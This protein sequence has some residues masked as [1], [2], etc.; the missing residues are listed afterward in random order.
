MVPPP[1]KALDAF[2]NLRRP[3]GGSPPLSPNVALD[4]ATRKAH[5][6]LGT[7]LGLMF[8]IS[9]L[10]RSNVGF[11]KEALRV[12]AHIGD[13][14]YALGAGIFFI[15]Y[16]G[17]EVPS[18][19]I[20]HRVGARVWLS[21]IMVTWGIAS[22]LMM[23]VRNESSFYL[24]RFLVGLAEA[25][26]SPGVVLYS[27]Y[28]FPERERGKALGTYYMG[29]PAAMVFGSV[30]SGTLMQVM[31]G[32]LGL[33]NWQWMF[34]IEGA[35][36]SI[37]G[38]IA[39]F[40][41]VSRPRDARWLTVAEREA[42]ERQLLHEESQ[43]KS[44]S[45]GTAL[46]AFWDLRVVRFIAIYFTVQFGTYGVIFYLPSR[47]AGLAGTQINSRVGLLVA[48]P[49]LCALLAL[50]LIT[51]VAD[52]TGLHKQFAILTLFLLTL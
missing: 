41:L 35:A 25:G 50:P 21:R 9:I 40:V 51:G 4:S 30:L 3:A 20:L 10:D 18:N 26:F 2:R 19:L 29:L 39:F 42:L 47:I 8:A 28:W 1:S 32:Y 46:A 34:L 15:G 6:R 43:R 36:A 13:M 33:R 12:D 31:Q 17:F 38:V 45:P 16:S 23:L 27:T 37:V 14:A 7:F 11:A 24:L 22:A 44:T 49:W 52:K 48:V 5:L